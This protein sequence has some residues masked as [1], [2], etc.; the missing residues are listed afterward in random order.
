MRHL[1]LARSF[2]ITGRAAARAARPA[3]STPTKHPRSGAAP[4]PQSRESSTA[5]TPTP[6]PE[7]RAA[8]ADRSPA[9]SDVSPQPRKGDGLQEMQEKGGCCPQLKSDGPDSGLS[10]TKHAGEERRASATCSLALSLASEKKGAPASPRTLGV[11]DR[12]DRIRTCDLVL[13]KLSFLGFS[14]PAPPLGSHLKTLATKGFWA[15]SA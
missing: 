5:S 8:A 14:D 9:A 4:A 7:R 1:N 2:L 10:S 11:T 13:P 6:A 15:A 12:G 3:S